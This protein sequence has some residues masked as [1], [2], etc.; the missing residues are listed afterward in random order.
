MFVGA[1]GMS[2]S[3]EVPSFIADVTVSLALLTMLIALFLSS[4]RVVR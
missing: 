3:L 4:Y 1:D 2:R